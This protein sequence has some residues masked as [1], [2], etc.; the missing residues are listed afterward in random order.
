MTLTARTGSGEP[1]LDGS[2][3]LESIAAAVIGG[4]SLLGGVGGVIPVIL[5]SLFVT[6][7]SNA[8]DQLRTGGYVRQILLGRLIIGAIFLDRIRLSRA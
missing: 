6:M 1:N 2:L 3:M 7:P 8:M 5:G 4:V